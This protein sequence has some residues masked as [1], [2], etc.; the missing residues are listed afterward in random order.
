M[1]ATASAEFYNWASKADDTATL[2]LNDYNTIEESGDKDS[3]L[4]K[5]LQKLRD[6]Q[7]FPGNSNAKMAIGLESHFQTP[8]IPYI[9]SSIDTILL[10][11]SYLEQILRE[12]HSHPKI[13]G[14]VIWAAWKPSGCYRM[15]LTDNNFKNLPTGDV[16]DKLTS[17]FGLT[18]GLASGTT[19]A[20]GFFE[21]S[22][23]HG[24][25]EVKITHPLVDSPSFGV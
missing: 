1:G 7:G 18:S 9:R 12:V 19:N 17:E 23:F 15:C 2:F 8:N 10:L 4:A 6:I 16:V 5:Y 24:D 21:A 3:I 22:L 11:A 20:N 13:Q 25:Y 14:I